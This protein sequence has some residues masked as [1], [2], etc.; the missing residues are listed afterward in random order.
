[1]IPP[2]ILPHIFSPN[3]TTKPEGSGF[4]LA[5]C[6][7]IVEHHGGAIRVASKVGV[8]TEFLVFLPSTDA[9]ADPPGAFC[10]NAAPPHPAPSVSAAPS[11]ESDASAVTPDSGSGRV[12]VVE[13]QADVARATCGLLKH[14]GYEN[15]HSANGEEAI[16]RYR[17]HL[18]SDEAIDVVL[19]DMTL[20]GG[21]SGMEVAAEIHRIDP[22]ARII[23]TSG[24]FAEDGLAKGLNGNFAAILPKP[25]SM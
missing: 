19:L 4:G 7:A 5:S 13:D 10:P 8:G 11:T 6:Q 22:L 24:Y 1:G 25:Y 16:A 15:L 2:E 23:A 9:A 18:D 17:E 12:L 20:P 21:L 3:F 14:L